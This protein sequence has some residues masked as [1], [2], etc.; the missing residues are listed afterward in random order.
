MKIL[1]LREYLNPI[2]IQTYGILG[3]CGYKTVTCYDTA[4]YK[5]CPNPEDIERS[6]SIEKSFEQGYYINKE[7]Y[8]LTKEQFEDPEFWNS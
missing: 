4:I 7:A 8:S 5:V 6:E 3:V 2:M 1:K